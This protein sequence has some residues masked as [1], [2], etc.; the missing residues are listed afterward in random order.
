MSQ[1]VV[2][3]I[4]E[5]AA[6]GRALLKERG[7]IERAVRMVAAA[8]RRNGRLFYAGAGTSGRLGI[9]DAAECPPTFRIPPDR[10]QGII[11]G[12]QTAIWRSV[13]GA[14]DSPR[15]GAAA[16]ESR[17]VNRRDVVVG[18]SASGRTPFVWGALAAAKARGARTILLCFN[19]RLQ[20]SAANRPDLVIAADV[21]PEVLTGSTRLKAGTATKIVLNILSTL[22]MTRLGKV[23]SNLMADL[24]ASNSKLRQ[25]AVRIVQAVT[26]ADAAAAL[27]A[28]VKSK[29]I[30]KSA[31]RRLSS[32]GLKNPQPSARHR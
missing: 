29:W 6:I 20:F 25:R 8:F 21:G 30:V 28:L 15:A 27:G 17:G 19:P 24:K 7:R 32:S 5:D 3:M 1:A 2:L 26:G 13:E 11:A 23:A 22:A 14:E 16:I 31:C 18:I 4:K 10:V 9:L 12:G